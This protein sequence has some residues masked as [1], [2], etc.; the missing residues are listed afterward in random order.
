[1]WK[2]N[3][4]FQK[5]YKDVLFHATA[6]FVIGGIIGFIIE[7]LYWHYGLGYCWFKTGFLRRMPILPIYGFI[8]GFTYLFINYI[9]KFVAIIDKGGFFG[10][11]KRSIFYFV[12]FFLASFLIELV[13]GAFFY[14]VLDEVRLWD[15]TL[16][17]YN[18][19][20][21]ACPLYSTLFGIAGVLLLNTVYYPLDNVIVKIESNKK[22]RVVLRVIT[23]AFIIAIFIDIPESIR[24]WETGDYPWYRKSSGNCS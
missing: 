2:V 12:L 17:A 14:Y 6:L 4:E 19:N 15:Y 13:T 16:E 23:I 1:M 11:I 3:K 9:D 21:F 22:S 10:F 20:G 7:T 8:V 24:Y 5:D 18:I